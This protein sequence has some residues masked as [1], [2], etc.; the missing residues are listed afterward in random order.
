MAVITRYCPRCGA[1]LPQ[2]RLV[3]G[4]HGQII[5]AVATPWRGERMNLPIDPIDWLR[6]QA[7]NGNVLAVLLRDVDARLKELERQHEAQPA[8]DAEWLDG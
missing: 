7:A 2:P 3:Y 5:G 8:P 4:Q 1:P 6:E